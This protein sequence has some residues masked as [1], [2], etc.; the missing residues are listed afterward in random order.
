[1]AGRQGPQC[2][3]HAR[4]RRL[5]RPPLAHS[6]RIWPPVLQFACDAAGSLFMSTEGLTLRQRRRLPAWLRRC[7]P[8]PP[9]RLPTAHPHPLVCAGPPASSVQL[10]TCKAPSLHSQPP[11]APQQCS[12]W[13]HRPGERRR[14]AAA[15]QQQACGRWRRPGERRGQQRPAAAHALQAG[16][17]SLPASSVGQA[18]RPEASADHAAAEAGSQPPAV[19]V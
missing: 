3:V 12:W 1:M 6:P 18:A 14:Q 9:R 4:G 2:G 8:S 7:S 11:P 5:L 15:Q 17:P 19:R 16:R 13:P 10:A